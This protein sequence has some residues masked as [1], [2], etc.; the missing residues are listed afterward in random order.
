MY[1]YTQSANAVLQSSRALAQRN[2]ATAVS[3]QHVLGGLMSVD[4]KANSI[5][6]HVGISKA[7]LFVQIRNVSSSGGEGSVTRILESASHYAT[8]LNSGYIST[9][10]LLLALVTEK[11]SIAISLLHEQGVSESKIIAVL[12]GELKIKIGQGSTQSFEED[13]LEY[14]GGEPDKKDAMD[15]SKFGVDLLEKARMGKIDPVIGRDSEIARITQILARRSKN[16]PIIVGEP[17]VGKSAVVEGLAM[18]ILHGEVGEALSGKRI[19]SLDIGSLVAGS[20]YRGEFEERL[21]EFVDVV[22]TDGN[23][24]VFID[25]IHNIVGAGATGESSMDAAEILKPLLSRGELQTIGATTLDEY[26]KYIEKDPALERRFQ[27]VEVSEPSVEEAVQI[28]EGVKDKYEAHH[29]VEIT[30]EAVVSACKL[31]ARYITDRFLPDKAFDLMDE[32]SSM[33]RIRKMQ[34][35]PVAS[36][37][38]AQLLTL[39]KEKEYSL[40]DGNIERANL[41]SRSMESLKWQIAEE[42]KALQSQVFSRPRITADDIAQVVSAQRKIPVNKITQSEAERM[43]SLEAELSRR[44]IGQDPAIKSI[45]LAIRRARAGLKDE[46]RP[47]GSFIFVGPTGVGKTQLTKA[48]SLCVFG[49]EDSMIR[50]DMSEFMEKHSVSKLIG[51]PPGY[52]G[53]D[54][55]GVLTEKIRRNPYCV[56]LFDEIEKAHPDVFNLLLQILD[57][58]RLTDSKG[59]VVDFKNAI[60]IMT[61]NA[62]AGEVNSFSTLGFASGGEM[63]QLSTKKLEDRVNDALKET[64]KPEFLNRLDEVIIFSHLTKEDVRKITDILVLELAKRLEV[65]NIKIFVSESAKNFI[66]DLGYQREYGARPLKRVIQRELEDKLSEEILKGNIKSG[67]RVR[68]EAENGRLVFTNIV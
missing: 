43:L 49:G 37:K 34:E 39:A 54:E 29:K 40:A 1:K 60:I 61:S 32:A 44:V 4:C 46:K 12:E 51:A 10:H 24:I 3:S 6:Q 63:L 30:H 11:S 13:K 18:K 7:N 33:V 59:R 42:K 28:L 31:S 64:F 58:G 52:A 8:N 47:I 21:K 20:K 56:V 22:K 48:L 50:M 25:E 23:I 62:G 9:E 19:F 36:E 5:L 16:N 68:V 35:K 38:E 26:R 67:S 66:S 41:I 15:I 14:A 65:Q 27:Q 55:A 57:D 17:G 53:H 2:N 45:A